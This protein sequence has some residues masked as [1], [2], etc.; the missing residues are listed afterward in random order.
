MGDYSSP[1]VDDTK[2]RMTQLLAGDEKA[3]GR[4]SA[5]HYS[6]AIVSNRHM[7]ATCAANC[8]Y[9]FATKPGS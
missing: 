5:L 9:L 4:F 1:T 7:P 2:L 8:A 3:W 6:R